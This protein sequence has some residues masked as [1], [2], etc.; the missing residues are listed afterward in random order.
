VEDGT[1][2]G[3]YRLIGLVG[4]GGMGE[5]WRAHDTVTDRIV[6]IK[7]LPAQYSDDPQ[8]QERFRREAHAAARLNSPHVIPIYDYGEI[9]GR[10]Y[11]TMRLIEGRDLHD[12]LSDGP[13]W[14]NRAVRIVEQ[15]AKAL[16]AAHKVGLVHR[17][18]KPSNVLI[19]EDDFAYLIDFGIARATDQTRMTGTG[20][21]IGTFQYMAP[22]RLADAPD[23]AR[24]DIYALA[25]VLY[26]C[27]TGQPPFAGTNVASLAG[28]HLHAPPPRPSIITPGLPQR[29]DEVIATGMAKDPG[30]RYATT[31]GLAEAARSAAAAPIASPDVA[32]TMPASSAGPTLERAHVAA[33]PVMP[34][35]SRRSSGRRLSVLV[36]AVIG[37]VIVAVIAGFVLTGREDGQRTAETTAT[38]APSIA[39]PAPADAGPLN[40]SYRADFGAEV[41]LGGKPLDGASPASGI[42]DFRSTCP[43]TGCVAVAAAAKEGP[44]LD[45]T[46]VFDDMGGTWVSVGVVELT[47]PKPGFRFS[48]P[49]TVVGEFWEV[50]ALQPKPDGTWSGDATTTGDNLCDVKRSVTLTRIGDVASSSVADPGSIPPRVS[51]PAEAL[52]GQYHYSGHETSGRYDD[53]AY[54]QIVQTYCLRS[55][56]RCWSYFH[57]AADT[58]GLALSFADGQWTSSQI[59]PPCAG[60]PAEGKNIAVFPLPRPV[61]DPIPVLTGVVHL[62]WAPGSRCSGTQNYDAKYQRT[63]D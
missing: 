33:E 60:V 32:K 34:P 17:D 20:N 27:L 14:T 38:T 63:G 5:V 41:D 50:I 26:E 18:V 45:S 25:C 44:T 1:S 43:P 23:D 35:P 8:F 15:V 4:R 42:Y 21:A 13:L 52:R 61:E 29:F 58:V 10:L 49:G 62:E 16:H 37:V 11:V 31:V 19:D 48:C 46:L 24:A 57:T 12:I 40:G 22:E 9:E 54:D 53:A 56:Q 7:L 6:A 55:G 59:D 2:F 51:S 3:R 36:G 39:G 47:A 30:Q 28:A